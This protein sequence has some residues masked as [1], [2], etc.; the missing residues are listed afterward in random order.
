MD[1]AFQYV[2]KAGGIVLEDSYLC[3]VEDTTCNTKKR[4]FIVTV[5]NSHAI[6]GEQNMIDHVL[7]GGTL[8]VAVDASD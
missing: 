3:D 1:T 6:V 7:T 4:D 8:S 5:V 2:R